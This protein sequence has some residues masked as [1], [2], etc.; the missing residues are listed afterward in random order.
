MASV[1]SDNVPQPFGSTLKLGICRMG[2]TIHPFFGIAV[3]LYECLVRIN[4]LATMNNGIPHQS[5][6]CRS[7]AEAI[8]LQLQSWVPPETSHATPL[9]MSEARAAAFAI[10]WAAMLRLRQLM[11]PAT[12]DSRDSQLKGP[13]EHI[14]SA[15]S[16]I[17]PGSQTESRLLF[18]LFIT[19]TSCTTKASRLTIEYRINIMERTI[20]FGNVATS[21]QILDEIWRQHNR[22][23]SVQWE[24]LVTTTTP[25][26]V[27][28]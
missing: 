25:G 17:R 15:V 4:M 5:M 21:H 27:L 7:E 18:P 10:Q 1:T 6:E 23:E 26:L 11:P 12:T 19:G 9:E 8:E 22:R 28:F 2:E 16:L 20:G 14:I 24:Q 13:T 3:E